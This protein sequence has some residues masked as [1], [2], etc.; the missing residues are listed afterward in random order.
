MLPAAPPVPTWPD[1][2]YVERPGGAQRLDLYLPEGRPGPWPV[3][4]WFHGGGWAAGDKGNAYV[5]FLLAHGIAVADVAYR[6]TTVAPAPAN[7]HDCRAAIRWLRTAG[8][9]FG[10][11]PARVAVTGGSAG[12]HLAL[13]CGADE[14]HPL[15]RETP[16]PTVSARPLAICA[17]CP[18]TDL[19]DLTLAAE[20]PRRDE[21]TGMLEA[22]LGGPLAERRALARAVSP[23][24]HAAAGFPPTLLIHGA[25]DTTVEVSHSRRL[26]AALRAAGAAVEYL[27]DPHGDHPRETW[28]TPTV[29]ARLTAFCRR[30]FGLP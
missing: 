12:G 28:D 6:L 24:T 29:H 16:A 25:A 21:F 8:P 27:E 20:H 10:L 3:V 18:P 19:V 5:T 15:L 1:L 9:R 13:L 23:I 30:I 22:L 14:T 7:L 11:D 2:S 17:L 26:A 4:T